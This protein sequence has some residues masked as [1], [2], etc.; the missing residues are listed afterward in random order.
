MLNLASVC[1]VSLVALYIYLHNCMDH[2][3]P[4]QPCRHSEGKIRRV[5]NDMC[6]LPVNVIKQGEGCASLVT[7]MV[8]TLV[9]HL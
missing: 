2:V 8:V 7:H 1:R 5:V 3:I 9:N 4:L 6:H